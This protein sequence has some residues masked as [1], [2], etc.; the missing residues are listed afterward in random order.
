[1][2]YIFMIIL[3]GILV[4]FFTVSILIDRRHIKK[5][6][7]AEKEKV[8]SFW[9][10]WGTNI[11]LENGTNVL[12]C[13]ERKGADDIN[14]FLDEFFDMYCPHIECLMSNK[15]QTSKQISNVMCI[16]GNSYHAFVNADREVDGGIHGEIYIMKA[17]DVNNHVV[18]FLKQHN[19]F[20]IL[21]T[22]DAGVKYLV[23][24]KFAYPPSPF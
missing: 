19:L 17:N 2:G 4:V 3:I 5:Y 21:Y 18:K 16:S 23:S 7:D 24:C 12:I 22:D 1:M 8:N 20:N 14:Q 13:H 10:T 15:Y 11:V 9:D 6:F